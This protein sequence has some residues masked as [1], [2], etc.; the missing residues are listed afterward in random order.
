MTGFKQLGLLIIIII[1]IATL[2]LFQNSTKMN[3]K[4]L[5]KIKPEHKIKKDQ[6]TITTTAKRN[7]KAGNIQKNISWIIYSLT[8]VAVF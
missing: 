7:R 5:S 8:I 3:I 6:T 1:V 2:L 4:T